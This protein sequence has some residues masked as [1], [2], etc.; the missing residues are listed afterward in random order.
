MG[1][2]SVRLSGDG[3][4]NVVLVVE[5]ARRARMWCAREEEEDTP[6]RRSGV[7]MLVLKVMGR[8]DETRWEVKPFSASEE[9]HASLDSEADAKSV[10][11]RGRLVRPKDATSKGTL[12]FKRSLHC[13]AWG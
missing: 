6:K 7:S 2:A 9:T 3:W 13:L 1:M 8:E 10:R 4:L 12:A 5:E 11:R